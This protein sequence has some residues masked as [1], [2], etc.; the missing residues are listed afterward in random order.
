[1]TLTAAMLLQ[2]VDYKTERDV[3]ERVTFSVS[4]WHQLVRPDVPSFAG[5][6]ENRRLS[7]RCTIQRRCTIEVR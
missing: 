5:L 1:M 4:Q 3:C 2:I 6:L 7:G